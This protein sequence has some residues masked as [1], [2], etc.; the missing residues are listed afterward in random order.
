M[1]PK[2]S[3]LN[4]TNNIP[5][6]PLDYIPLST[7]TIINQHKRQMCIQSLGVIIFTLQKKKSKTRGDEER[8]QSEAPLPP[9]K[10]SIPE[11]DL[12]A[13]RKVA[14]SGGI[15]RYRAETVERWPMQ[16]SKA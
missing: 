3:H 10:K 11:G 12:A 6:N 14:D 16:V 8:H 1:K 7:L 13:P 15:Q 9:L 5:T 4:L 2:T